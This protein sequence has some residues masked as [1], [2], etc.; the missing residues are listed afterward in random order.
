M[1]N[2]KDRFNRMDYS[3]KNNPNQQMTI[4]GVA[5]SNIT[6]EDILAFCETKGISPEYLVLKLIENID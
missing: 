4:R 3:E 5:I 6:K 2:Y 1:N